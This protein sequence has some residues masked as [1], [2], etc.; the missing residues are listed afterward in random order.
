MEVS[1]TTFP[2]SFYSRVL[3]SVEK[4]ITKYSYRRR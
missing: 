3:Y 2:I 1:V 4:L